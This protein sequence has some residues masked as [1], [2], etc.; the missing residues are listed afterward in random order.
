VVAALYLLKFK[1][2]AVVV[3]DTASPVEPEDMPNHLL[4]LPQLD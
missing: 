1:A 4:K 2:V 3:L